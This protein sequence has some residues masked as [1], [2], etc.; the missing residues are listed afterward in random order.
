MQ[1][2]AAVFFPGLTKALLR[3]KLLILALIPMITPLW[4]ANAKFSQRK[5]LES[6]ALSIAIRRQESWK[7]ASL[8]LNLNSGV[9][10][11]YN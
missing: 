6:I 10:Y 1:K 11:D 3:T 8:H 7:A 4:L 9:G 2:L 5:P